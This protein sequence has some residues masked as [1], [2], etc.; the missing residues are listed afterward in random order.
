VT[1]HLDP[2]R[3]RKRDAI[4]SA[5][6]QEQRKNGLSFFQAPI[7]GMVSSTGWG[8]SDSNLVKVVRPD[9]RPAPCVTPSIA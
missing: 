3:R 9:L 1:P 4:G 5:P 8:S 2:D 7:L 6:K